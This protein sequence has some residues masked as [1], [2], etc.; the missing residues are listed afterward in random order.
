MARRLWFAAF[1]SPW[2]GCSDGG[3]VLP[4]SPA[5]AAARRD[6]A[7][8]GSTT[9]LSQDA[10]S[11]VIVDSLDGRP[12][13]GI[14]LSIGDA[15][16]TETGPDGTFSLPATATPMSLRIEGEGFFERHTRVAA[17]SVRAQIDILPRG[18]AFDLDFF[19]HVFRN[20]GA[21]GTERW[22]R[23]PRFEIWTGIYDC[24]TGEF[25]GECGDLV[26]SGETAPGQFVQVAR[27]VI[28]ADA[29]KL[30]GGFVTGTS[31]FTR[32]PHP[33]GTRLTW[34]EYFQPYT[35]TVVMVRGIDFSFAWLWPYE[36]GAYYAGTMQ[37]TKQ[38]HKTDP[39][40]HSHE[41]AHALGFSHPAG[42]DRVPL[43]SIM[44][45]ARAVTAQ[46]VLHGGILYRRPPGSRTADSDPDDFVIN[47]LRIPGGGAP[48]PSRIRVIR[49]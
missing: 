44:R 40:V 41:L 9:N 2:L 33:A 30:S 17:S 16:S 36:S 45:E 24:E 46:D 26:S 7:V 21:N 11:G 18:R 43:P 32:E 12:L 15:S 23:E 13:P 42:Y 20:L 5:A 47:A 37:L 1:L 27:D 31:L 6:L 10:L 14:T 22:I 19:D 48:D 35:I 49:N 34:R 25:E 38:E 28:L 29:P 8:A 39:A 3:E 4:T